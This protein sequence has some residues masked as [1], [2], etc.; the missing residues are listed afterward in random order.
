V[1]V[2]YTRLTRASA[3]LP[4][5]APVRM[6]HLG[7]GNFFRAHQAWYTDAAPD[8]GSWGIAAFTGRSA[9]LANTLRQQQGTYTLVTRAASGPALR[10]IGSISAVHAAAEHQAW[11]RYLATPSVS[12]VTLTVTEAGYGRRQDGTP[13]LSLPG[14]TEDLTGLKSD[15]RAEVRT[16]PA[17]LVA[18]L[19]ARRAAGA[20]PLSVVP[21]DNLPQNGA[22]VRTLALALAAEVDPGLADWISNEIEFVTTMVDR[23]TPATTEEDRQ[24]VRTLTGLD[25]QAPVTTEPY[26]EW[27]LAGAFPAGR[28]DWEA[29]GAIVVDDVE[30][31]ERRKLWLLNG[32]HSLLAYG[33]TLRGHETVGQGMADP[34]V[35][36]W[37][38]EWWDAA[39]RHL[40]QDRSSVDSYR[41]A[42]VD[43]FSNPEVHHLLSQVAA[44]GSQKIPAR[45]LP[46]LRAELKEGRLT[47][48]V[49]RVLAVWVLYL[50]R[51]GGAGDPGLDVAGLADEPIR[52]AVTRVLSQVA[53]DLAADARVTGQVTS[54]ARTVDAS[55]RPS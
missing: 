3:K 4:E 46:V 45:T 43:R 29:A 42:L 39:A 11:L 44:D 38:D 23:I 20:G 1:T 12:L 48:G 53:P 52:T 27:I 33:A 8:A 32:A 2:D 37:V 51:H 24:L 36:G 55:D 9:S 16:A 28:P 25:D 34:V 5:A 6:V 21:C 40:D 31:Y 54:L 7:L 17:R 10:H 14:V 30:P 18:G 19:G 26:S 49:F 13:D 35:R 15:L 22:A 41:V 47:G 50:M